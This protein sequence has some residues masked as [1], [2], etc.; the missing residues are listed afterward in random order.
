[1]IDGGQSSYLAP[2][3]SCNEVF[4]QINQWMTS[5]RENHAACGTGDVVPLPRR[6]VDVG[7][8]DITGGY[9]EPLLCED[10]NHLGNYVTLS[11]RWWNGMTMTTT[12]STLESRKK[13][14]P[15]DSMPKTFQDA[16]TTTRKLGIRYLWIDALCIIQDLVQDWEEQSAL[17]G[18]IYAG[19]S[20][21]LSVSGATDFRKG[22][23]HKRNNLEICGCRHPSLL[24]GSK[25]WNRNK[26]KIAK[27]ICP[28][29]P[30]HDRLYDRDPLR[31][32]GW[33]LQEHALSKR[34]LH[35][36]LYEVYWECLCLSAS[37]R[38]PEKM[39]N[40]SNAS[41]FDSH[42]Q[43][44]RFSWIAIR[45]GV[46]YLLNRDA[47]DLLD[48][49]GP[50]SST[51]LCH[52][53]PHDRW[54][55]RNLSSTPKK[56]KGDFYQCSH[57]H[58]QQPDYANR[59]H[60]VGQFVAAHHLWYRLIEEYSLRF[61]TM[62]TDKLPAVSGLVPGF[63][64][65]FGDRSKYVAGIWTG[66]ALNGLLWSPTSAGVP[67][68]TKQP[69]TDA[70]SVETTYIAPSFSW[71]SFNGPVRFDVVQRNRLTGDD[72]YEAEVLNLEATPSGLNSLGGVS[73][74]S[75]TL[76]AWAIPFY[77]IIK[78]SRSHLSSSPFDRDGRPYDPPDEQVLCVS[79]RNIS[80]GYLGEKPYIL[81]QCL[82]VLPTEGGGKA[83]QR[84]GTWSVPVPEAPRPWIVG[85]E[86][87]NARIAAALKIPDQDTID[88]NKHPYDGWAKME[89]TIV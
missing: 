53:E 86:D 73:G 18:E 49:L 65:V 25:R 41:N 62:L 22:F 15:L 46:Q 24:T 50:E 79:V 63:Q 30:R 32:R 3:P 27:V 88:D 54:L 20:L 6:V 84:V 26:A 40:W 66:D 81:R 23:L 82:L 80:T 33:I 21:N 8:P 43:K 71:A 68:M 29:V 44:R 76:R 31:S 1:M 85:G 4:S 61:L 57:Y 39:E 89:I 52:D 13:G 72:R 9:P 74:G 64:K 78:E 87:M 56:R 35:F 45:S 28:N 2:D 75:V 37:E 38:E 51:P 69:L 11:Y 34:T 14:I 83:Y 47:E 5:C 67:G 10:A 12:S 58:D 36:G 48:I 60:T 55:L 70:L 16:V 7:E 17:M 19:S 77:R 59:N 42:S